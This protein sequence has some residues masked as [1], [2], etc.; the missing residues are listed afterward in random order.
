[1]SFTS[2]YLELQKK[3]KKT[4]H[5][6]T[7]DYLELAEKRE[8]EEEAKKVKTTTTSKKTSDDDIAPVKTTEERKWFQKGAF[9]DGYQ[10]GDVIK[11]IAASSEDL[12]D[13]VAAGIL[14]IG[15]KV[16]DAGAYAV[17]GIANLLGKASGNK[18]HTAVADMMKDFVAKD[19]YDE[20]E[21]AKKLPLTTNP[22]YELTTKKILGIDEEEDSI[23]GDKADSVAQSGGQLIAQIGL[24]AVGVPWFV[25]SGVTSFGSE[26]E[27]AFNEGATYGEAGV[28][29]LITAGAEIL[30][31]KISGGIKFGKMGTLDE[32]LEISRK[33]RHGHCR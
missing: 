6:F 24:Q 7:D 16:V 5:T 31:E 20:K 30:T 26:V 9:E 32:I 1:M 10:F 17:G 4:G 19:L 14:G 18:E 13:N 23:F 27:S 25:T 28:S 11:T 29:G 2:E 15:E 3:R 8:A 12:S 22:I 33:A 21:L